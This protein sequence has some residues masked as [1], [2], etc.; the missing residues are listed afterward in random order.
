[1]S[2]RMCYDISKFTKKTVI[3]YFYCSANPRLKNCVLNEKLKSFSLRPWVLGCPFPTP[4]FRVFL[5]LS[6]CMYF[7][8]VRKS[9]GWTPNSKWA[10]YFFN[11]LY[12]LRF[13]YLKCLKIRNTIDLRLRFD[14]VPPF[15][16]HGKL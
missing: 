7:G 10:R 1:M 6:S 13:S 12:I 11:P 15:Y 2:V 8:L 9:P 16:F 3:N 5:Y 4:G 14:V